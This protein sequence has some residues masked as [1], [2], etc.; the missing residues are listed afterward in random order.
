VHEVVALE[1][2]AV[3]LE[4]PTDDSVEVH[5]LVHFSFSHVHTSSYLLL[6]L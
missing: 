3:L 1:L 5:S 6:I 4:N 2:L